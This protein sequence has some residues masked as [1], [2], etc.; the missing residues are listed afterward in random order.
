VDVGA[1]F[2]CGLTTAG[3]AYC[4]GRDYHGRLGLGQVAAGDVTPPAPV[5]GNQVFAGITAGINHAC[6]W[7]EDGAAYCWG[8]NELGAVGAPGTGSVLVPTAVQAGLT[9]TQ[10]DA[11]EGFTCGIASDARTYCWGWHVDAWSGQP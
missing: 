3:T 1:L 2:T 9:F 6:A 8:D 10:L 7:T 4:W 5:M 11:G